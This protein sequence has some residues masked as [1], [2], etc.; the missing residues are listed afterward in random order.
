M[1]QAMISQI[2]YHKHDL[3]KKINYKLNFTKIRNFWSSGD[4]VKRKKVKLQTGKL[5][6]Q[7]SY[8]IKFLYLKYLQNYWN[9]LISRQLQKRWPKDFNR[10][11]SKENIQMANMHIKI[12]SV[13]LII[14]EIKIKTLMRESY[15]LNRI[16]KINGMD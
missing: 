11:F 7:T 10:H 14:M 4:T 9:L 16:S 13:S 15:K 2:R 3:H 12:F 8:L 6:W 5:I 1:G